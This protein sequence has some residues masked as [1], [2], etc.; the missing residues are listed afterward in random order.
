M[1]SEKVERCVWIIGEPS[2]LPYL[3]QTID[4]PAPNHFKYC[5]Y[6]GKRILIRRGCKTK[7]KADG[8]EEP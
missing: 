2:C 3:W 5:P 8:K 4:P 6:C 7:I 1:G